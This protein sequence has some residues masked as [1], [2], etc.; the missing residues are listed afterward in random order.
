[1]S[2][3]IAP[4]CQVKYRHCDRISTVTQNIRNPS[5]L[6]TT[7]LVLV[8]VFDI[9]RKV[10]VFSQTRSNLGEA[11]ERWQREST[12]CGVRGNCDSRETVTGRMATD[13]AS[14]Y[15]AHPKASA[16]VEALF[17]NVIVN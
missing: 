7:S 3:K 12:E 17:D 6:T 15:H 5:R 1:M 14:N 10:M 9:E 8:S 11:S 4:N 13:S 2:K 16:N